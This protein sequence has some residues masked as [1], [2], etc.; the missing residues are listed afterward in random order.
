MKSERL[1]I[2]KMLEQGQITTQEAGELLSAVEK[3]K[4]GPGVTRGR[5]MRVRVVETSSGRDKVNVTVP[6]GLVDVALRM[7]ARFVPKTSE[8]DPQRILEAIHDGDKGLIM[9]FEDFE[10]EERVEIYID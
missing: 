10:A 6:L 1:Q 2:L 9:K 7:G 5:W 8:F 3:P 4:S